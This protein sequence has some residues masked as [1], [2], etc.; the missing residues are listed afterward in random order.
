MIFYDFDW[1]FLLNPDNILSSD[2]NINVMYNQ[3]TEEC[4]NKL[5]LALT[6]L[7]VEVDPSLGGLSISSVLQTYKSIIVNIKN[8][9][10]DA[11]TKLAMNIQLRVTPFITSEIKCKQI[12]KG[13][14]LY[15]MEYLAYKVIKSI[16]KFNEDS[17]ITS[18][19]PYISS[20]ILYDAIL[21]IVR[22]TNNDNDY[23]INYIKN[24]FFEL[25]LM[26]KYLKGV[27][28]VI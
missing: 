4:N 27:K 23:A 12:W 17:E 3:L 10:D 9:L 2:R 7:L 21:D 20:E 14:Y 28:N 25:I 6:D 18:C 19:A 5:Y 13:N 8:V 16:E 24:T 1:S 26:K 15:I 11:A 22:L